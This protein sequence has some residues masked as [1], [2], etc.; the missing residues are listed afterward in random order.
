MIAI[1]TYAFFDI[2]YRGQT[3][4]CSLFSFVSLLSCEG[5]V[6]VV[7]SKFDVLGEFTLTNWSLGLMI[8]SD[9]GSGELEPLSNLEQYMEIYI[10]DSCSTINITFHSNKIVIDLAKVRTHIIHAGIL[11]TINIRV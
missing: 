6:L 5:N 8:A 10:T 9:N 7:L 4:S 2:H 11:V 3:F 1:E